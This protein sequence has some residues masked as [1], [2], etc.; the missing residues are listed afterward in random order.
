MW[1]LKSP[2]ALL[3]GWLEFHPVRRDVKHAVLQHNALR[4]HATRG[5][6]VPLE[7][8]IGAESEQDDEPQDF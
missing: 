2:P 4:N 6:S 5:V 7:D 3:V 1:Q 8:I